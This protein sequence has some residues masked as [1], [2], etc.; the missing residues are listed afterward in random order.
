MEG[1]KVKKWFQKSVVS[2]LVLILAAG[3]FQPAISVNAEDAL[4]VNAEAAIIVE[5]ETG[6][7]IYEKNSET[8][9]GIASM[10]KMMTEYL[11]LEAVN[12]GKVDWEQEYTIP[13]PLS[14]LSHK[15]GLSNVPLRAEAQYTVKELYQAMAIYS[16]NAATMAIANIVAGSESNF[17][18]MMNDKAGELGLESY[19]FV[20]ATGLNNR[21]LGEM[22]PE[23]TGAEEENVMSAKDTAKLAYHLLNEYP[24]VLE[25]SRIP[26]MIFDEGTEDAVKMENWNWMLPELVYAY[27]GMDGLK[28]GTTDFAGYCF[29]GTAE[30]NGTRYITVVMDAHPN[31]G[32]NPYHARFAQT[33]N[34]MNYAFNNFTKEEI[35]PANYEVKGQKVLPVVKGKEKE[36]AIHSKEP[37]KMVVK[38]GEK[39]FKPK[40]VLDKKKLNEDQQLTAPVKDEE[41]VGYLTIEGGDDLGYIT[42]KASAHGQVPVVTAEAV[43]K[44]NWFVLSMRAVGGFF[45]DIWGSV[46]S[47]VKGWF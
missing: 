24:E 9:L 34:M 46:T 1:Y 35:F 41:K 11:L 27:E 21:D 38:N 13:V 19:K 36:V 20:N 12:E 42:E 31:E 32:E 28:T 4:N 40:L 30:R 39:E 14:N 8:A 22:R 17:I 10:T 26:R 43:E 16:A 37:L 5:A 45:S 2:F 29:T 23:G 47:T 18:K 6:K 7:I 15:T 3:V 33:A 44:A 25:T